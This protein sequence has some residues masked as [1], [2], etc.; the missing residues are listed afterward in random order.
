M[1]PDP[2]QRLPSRHEVGAAIV[3]S[4]NRGRR[5]RSLYR[6]LCSVD[7]DRTSQQQLID[8]ATESGLH[9]TT[10]DT[11]DTEGRADG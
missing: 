9:L 1:E 4:A 8:H 5:L 7:A 10:G 3:D 2:I 11:L 6:L